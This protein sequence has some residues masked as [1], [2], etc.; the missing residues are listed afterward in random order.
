[1]TK[2]RSLLLSTRFTRILVT[3]YHLVGALL[4]GVAVYALCG[5]ALPVAGRILVA[6]NSAVLLYMGVVFFSMLKV[7]RTVQAMRARAEH[8]DEGRGIVL[9]LA[10][11]TALL[12]LVAILNELS[13]AASSSTP[14]PHL[15]LAGATVVCSW[16]FLH[17]IFALHYA[18]VYYDDTEDGGICEGLHF[19]GNDD[20]PDYCDFLYFSYVI[21]TSAQTADIEISGRLMRRIGLVH[22]IL[23]FFFNTTV[24]ALTINAAAGLVG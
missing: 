22:C 19:P 6:W 4:F 10:I 2:K 8:Y 12:S 24:L 7:K 17:F 13:Y 21:G 5:D 20:V 14:I 23:S 1:M 3:H 15:A 9:L 11:G 18:H 16:L